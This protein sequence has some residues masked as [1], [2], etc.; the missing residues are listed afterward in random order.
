MESEV[1]MISE[2]LVAAGLDTGLNF[3]DE[4]IRYQAYRNAIQN[5]PLYLQH[6]VALIQPANKL[7]LYSYCIEL[8]L[9]DGLLQ[10][11]E[12][13]LLKNIAAALRL[14][15]DEQAVCKK[16]IVQRRLVETEKVF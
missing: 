4:I 3:T 1:R 2:K 9:S 6:L 8:C 5:E 16:L 11:E 14:N 15:D 7:A 10:P 12:E 13:S